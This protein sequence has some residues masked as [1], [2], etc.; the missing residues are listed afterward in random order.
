MIQLPTRHH[1]PCGQANPMVGGW[2][3][4]RRRPPCDALLVRPG[5]FIL[6]R[7]LPGPGAAPAKREAGMNPS[8]VRHG[9]TLTR[10]DRLARVAARIPAGTCWSATDRYQAAWNAIVDLLCTGTPPPRPS[11]LIQ[12]GR[13]GILRYANTERH[14]H[15][16]VARAAW[17]GDATTPAFVRYWWEQRGRTDDHAPAI[18]DR[19]AL[20]RIWPALRDT[21]RAA[22]LA[23][24]AHGTAQAAA[25]ALGL[26]RHTYYL[27]LRK[28]RQAALTLWH[29][30]QTPP[31]L[32]RDCR[33]GSYQRGAAA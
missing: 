25:D 24:A 33:V 4:C 13:E 6:M 5:G 15:G 26:Q 9:Y 10:L 22:L 19:L 23:L 29:E 16:V 7:P 18:I 27:R 2:E 28:A 1:S 21:D 12:A 20:A 3:G 17:A 32:R 14:H 30:G 8:T 31:R 11:H